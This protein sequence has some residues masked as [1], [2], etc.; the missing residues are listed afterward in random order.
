MTAT[1]LTPPNSV[2][3][4]KNET[5]LAEFVRAIDARTQ[6]SGDVDTSI[7]GLTFF[8]REAPTD[9]VT[10]MI[11][12]SVVLVAQ[13]EKRIWIGGEAYRYDISHF[14]LTSLDLPA[15]SEVITAS[16]QEPCL[17]LTLKLDLRIVAELI[18]QGCLPPRR[19]RG[20]SSSAGIGSATS[21]ILRPFGRLL[22][23]LEEPEAIPVLAPLLQ[24]EIHFRLLMSDQATRLRHI[25]SIDSQGHR[26][27]RAIGWLKLHYAAPLRVEEL[28]AR[29][30]MSTPT[31]HQHF[32]K[33][34]SMSPLQY[35]KWIR[36]NEAR[37]LMLN[38]HLDVSSAAFKVGYESPSQ[39]S[40]E[41]RRLFGVPAKKDITALRAQ[42]PSSGMRS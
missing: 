38:E 40:R 17:G 11:E 28:A 31:F 9:P 8:R 13:G 7:D 10:C 21:A 34:T 5:Q 23:L 15:N 4:Q 37:R 25:A 16:R 32:R 41:Y 20:A 18:A 30:Q 6:G 39:F 12:P 35:Q 1:P 2:I 27:A 29:V 24:R 3:S 22:E 42:I 19:D 36:L 26:I 33:L 14:L